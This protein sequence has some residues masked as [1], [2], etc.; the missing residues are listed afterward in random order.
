[1]REEID[2]IDAC[3]NC[4]EENLNIL[5]CLHTSRFIADGAV[6]MQFYSW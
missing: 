1:M 4:A 5:R 2:A 3:T 6:V